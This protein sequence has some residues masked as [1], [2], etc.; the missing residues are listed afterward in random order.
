MYRARFIWFIYKEGNLK[1]VKYV[2][3]NML[4][5]CECLCVTMQSQRPLY[6]WETRQLQSMLSPESLLSLCSVHFWVVKSAWKTSSSF[7][8]CVSLFILVCV[9]VLCVCLI[10]LPVGYNSTFYKGYAKF[11]IPGHSNSPE[12]VSIPGIARVMGYCQHKTIPEKKTL[13]V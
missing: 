2:K 7:A 13:F 1:G 6:D 4:M 5:S 10:F 12:Q 11:L 8:K 3:Q 9:F